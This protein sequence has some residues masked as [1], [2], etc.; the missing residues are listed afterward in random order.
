[1]NREQA[2]K[3]AEAVRDR[4]SAVVC[5][6]KEQWRESAQLDLDTIVNAHV[7]QAGQQEPAA[8]QSM[9]DMR[10]VTADKK[11][12]KQW[13]QSGFNPRPLYTAPPAVAMPDGWKLVPVEPTDGM[14]WALYGFLVGQLTEPDYQRYHAMLAAAP[15][16]EEPAK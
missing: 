15:K 7:A 13:A 9:S 3:L 6:S 4:L 11:L 5:E 10:F 8:W 12:A 16:P 1:M 14:L 2:M